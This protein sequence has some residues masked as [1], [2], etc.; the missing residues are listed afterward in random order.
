MPTVS[1]LTTVHLKDAGGP[2][3]FLAHFHYDRVD[4][5]AVRVKF[6]DQGTAVACWY[7]DRE[8]LAEGM[9]RQIGEGDVTFRPRRTVEGLQVHIELRDHTAPGHHAAV[10][11]VDGGDLDEFLERTY[12]V[13]PAGAETMD[14]DSPLRDL[15]AW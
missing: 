6:F 2:V 8:M 11:S 9:N 1:S 13:T 15:L 14:I 7:F 3:P 5:Y 12:R 4:P 10:I